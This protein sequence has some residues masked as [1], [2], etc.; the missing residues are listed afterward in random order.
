[1][2]NVQ[3]ILK[4]SC[5]GLLF[6]WG[7]IQVGMFYNHHTH[8]SAHAVKGGEDTKVERKLDNLLKF[9]YKDWKKNINTDLVDNGVVVG[10]T[11]VPS[12]KEKGNTEQLSSPTSVS[13]V[14]SAVNN[15]GVKGLGDSNNMGAR[16]G[17]ND[18]L[19]STRH[20]DPIYRYIQQGKVN[21]NL[22]FIHIKM[23]CHVIKVTLS[24]YIKIHENN[25]CPT[26]VNIRSTYQ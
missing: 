24:M 26:I 23:F 22:S 1:M 4:Y 20:K 18:F 25:T 3:R 19:W 10:P 16:G 5:I 12:V 11:I 15:N 17:E 13:T 14:S 8:M 21:A 2:L 9:N 6:F 7:G